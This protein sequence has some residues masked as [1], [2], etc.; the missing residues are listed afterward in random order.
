MLDL[1]KEL[2]TY[3]FNEEIDNIES[4]PFGL[5]N[6]SQVLTINNKKYIARIYDN[7]SKNLEKLK[8]EIELTT[9]LEQQDLSFKLPGFLIAK[10]EDRF[11]ELS[12]GQFGSVMHFIEGEVPDLTR[13]SDIK[14][15]GKTVGE[16]SAAFKKFKSD[17]LIRDIKFY[18]IY[19]LHSLSNERAVSHFI[20]QP[21][22]DIDHNQLSILK[23][24]FQAVQRNE[25][26]IDALPKQII[27]H[28][29]LIFNLLIDSKTRKMNGVLDFDFASHDVCALELAI[30][31][32]HLLQFDDGS[33]LNLELFLDEYSQH[34]T[35]T[36][37]EIKWIPFLM[38]MYYVS[39]ICIYIGQYYSGR[40]IDNYF[41]F[42]LNQ[43][44]IRTQWIEQ[45]EYELIETLR[46]RLN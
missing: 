8:F 42:I 13:I 38:Q 26:I 22:F 16:I 15:Y 45:N 20:D 21:P 3:Y 33:L 14:E 27:H 30:C 17:T 2:M 35:L 28:D 36:D 46:L 11:V 19:N 39:L 9:F 23:N 32:N 41:R 37:E 12:N 24:T 43:L 4:V 40:E 34:M 18:N 10:T 1:I 7:H 44:V 29:I 5:T 25:S 6:Y 31:I